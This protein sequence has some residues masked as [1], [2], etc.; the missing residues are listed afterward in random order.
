MSAQMASHKSLPS[1]QSEVAAP[2]PTTDSSTQTTKREFPKRR[3]IVCCDGTWKTGDVVA[4][5]LSNV[6]KISRC[7]DKTD[8]YEGRYISQIVHYQ[9]GIGVGT[10][11]F[12]ANVLDAMT[13]SGKYLLI[14][15]RMEY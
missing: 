7:I 6:A 11:W 12:G 13:A 9:N 4:K 5:S 2:P 14:L 15:L 10:N 3:L 1:D 8:E